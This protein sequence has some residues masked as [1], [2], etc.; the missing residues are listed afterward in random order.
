MLMVVN[1]SI[2]HYVY[3][4]VNIGNHKF[5]RKEFREPGQMYSIHVSIDR[6]SFPFVFALM[7]KVDK[8]AY[9]QLFRCLQSKFDEFDKADL[10]DSANWH[11]DFELAAANACRSVFGNAK[12][13]GCFFHFLQA[14]KMKKAKCKLKTAFQ[15]NAELKL[16]Y[17]RLQMCAF[18]PQRVINKFIP[19]FLA[20]AKSDDAI[21]QFSLNQFVAYFHNTWM[22]GGRELLWC[23]WMVFGARTTNYLEGKYNGLRY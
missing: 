17:R 21:T 19:N 16:W 4:S 9:E 20:T 6:E 8:N 12:I 18:L 2:C 23:L 15:Q 11:F 5:N 22:K 10:I 3:F 7:Q 13:I 14:L 1:C